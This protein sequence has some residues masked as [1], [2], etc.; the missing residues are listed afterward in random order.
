MYI[1][2]VCIPHY[3]YMHTQMYVY[4]HID[5]HGHITNIDTNNANI[6]IIVTNNINIKRHMNI[7]LMACPSSHQHGTG[8]PHSAR[9]VTRGR[10]TASPHFWGG[11]GASRCQKN[12][13]TSWQGWN[14]PSLKDGVLPMAGPEEMP[15]LATILLSTASRQAFIFFPL[16]FL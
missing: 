4:T 7:N 15:L 16:T 10:A 14:E 2:H 9:A 5:V 3:I 6:N 12:N 11:C 13:V 1:L 8:L